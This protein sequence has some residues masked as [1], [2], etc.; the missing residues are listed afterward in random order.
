VLAKQQANIKSRLGKRTYAQLTAEMTANELKE[1]IEL[2]LEQNK[3]RF[4]VLSKITE[5]I[6]NNVEKSRAN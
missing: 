6:R 2:S 3:K 4:A 1:R 5:G